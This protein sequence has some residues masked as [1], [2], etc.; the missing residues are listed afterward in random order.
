MSQV[1]LD[2]AAKACGLLVGA[3]TQVVLTNDQRLRLA[4][5]KAANKYDATAD[6]IIEA[7]QK[8]YKFLKGES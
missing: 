2:E 1:D 8:F 3:A 5:L 6:E 7:A 4:A